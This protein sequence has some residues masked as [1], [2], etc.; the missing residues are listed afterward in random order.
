MQSYQVQ[1]TDG[2]LDLARIATSG[3]MFRWVKSEGGWRVHDGDAVYDLTH[4]ESKLSVASNRAE[5]EF[6]SLFRLDQ[7]HENLRDEIARLGPELEPALTRLS[8]LRMMRPACAREVLFSFL[9]SANNHI[10]RI[11]SMVWKLS[12]PE[13]FQSLEE[14]AE[15]PELALRENGFGYRAKSIPLVAQQIVADGGEKMLDQLKNSS[16]EEARRYLLAL[17]GVGPKLADCICLFAFDHQESVPIDTH[18]WQQLT[19]LYHPEWQGSALTHAKYDYSAKAF[20][21]RFGP[22]A[23]AAHQ[24]LFVEN[25][26]K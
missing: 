19:K 21:D 16:Y 22:L 20:R 5:P 2:P 24:F 26:S 11:T 9:C 6:R 12:T 1:I 4:E 25:M 10:A 3:Q 13:S 7:N 18:I 8:G 14:I 17:P 15:T 23:G